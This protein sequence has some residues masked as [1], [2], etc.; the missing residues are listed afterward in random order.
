MDGWVQREEKV[1]KNKM[2]KEMEAS[3]LAN[4]ELKMN[5]AGFQ[6]MREEFDV[7]WWAM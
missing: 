2:T 3:R 1:T 6:P 7:E 5:L 4:D